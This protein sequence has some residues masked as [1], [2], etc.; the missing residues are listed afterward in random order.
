M[1]LCLTTD[2]LSNDADVSPR[3]CVSLCV[4]S[5]VH[6]AFLVVGQ[7]FNCISGFCSDCGGGGDYLVVFVGVVVVIM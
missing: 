1:K 4:P 2:D 5:V 6:K 3:R 7:V